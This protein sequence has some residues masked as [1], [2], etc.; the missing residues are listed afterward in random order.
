M[1]GSAPSPPVGRGSPD[2]S[3]CRASP[4]AP[5]PSRCARAAAV[6]SAPPRWR[7]SWW[8]SSP[9][10]SRAGECRPASPASHRPRRWPGRA[11]SGRTPASAVSRPSGLC[12]SSWLFGDG[13]SQ[14]AQTRSISRSMKRSQSATC[15]SSMNSLG[16]CACSMEPGPQTTEGM[17]LSAK[18]PA[19]VPK[20]TR[21]VSFASARA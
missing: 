4:R 19:S 10:A 7:R 14:A 8:R 12:R 1:T 2:G 18:R 17:P 21:P 13:R 6:R 5:R 9:P 3:R 15:S 16:L 11:P 20:E